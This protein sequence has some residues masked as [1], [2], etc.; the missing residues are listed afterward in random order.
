VTDLWP[1][2]MGYTFAVAIADWLIKRLSATLWAALGIHR[3]SPWH[4]RLV[5]ILER[6]LYVV[7]LQTETGEFIGFWL[8][9]KVAGQWSLW[10]V[11]DGDVSGREFFNTFLIGNGLSILFAVVGFKM[12]TWW[13]TGDVTAFLAAP[14][15]LMLLTLAFGMLAAKHRKHNT[16]H[17]LGS[18]RASAPASGPRE[19]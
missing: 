15:G 6:L 2:I 9:I 4:P 13:A 3:P 17:A 16:E 11:G 8:A 19:T 1:H 10:T 12:I 18:P 5:G 14:V 7:A